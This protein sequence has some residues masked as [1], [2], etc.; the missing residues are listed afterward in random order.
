MESPSFP[1]DLFKLEYTPD[2]IELSIDIFYVFVF[3]PEH[4]YNKSEFYTISRF[5]IPDREV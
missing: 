3:F 2:N 5:T 4:L 1:S